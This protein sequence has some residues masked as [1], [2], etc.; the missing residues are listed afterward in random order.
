MDSHVINEEENESSR[1][2]SSQDE[3]GV[4]EVI[5]DSKLDYSEPSTLINV[6]E[7]SIDYRDY[8]SAQKLTSLEE[9]EF[10]S[11]LSYEFNVFLYT[12]FQN[13][14]EKAEDVGKIVPDETKPF[15][16][17]YQARDILE[18]LL[19]RDLKRY[20]NSSE[21]QHK[22]AHNGGQNLGESLDETK[23]NESVD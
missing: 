1:I 22:I 19:K 18:N 17:K 7:P 9:S 14:L 13:D 5:E 11:K 20:E 3:S 2:S 8:N 21:F 4:P 23:R 6:T 12:K 15:E 16:F 10:D